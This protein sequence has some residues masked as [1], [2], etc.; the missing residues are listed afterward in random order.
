VL[1]WTYMH[2]IRSSRC[3]RLTHQQSEATYDPS[4]SACLHVYRVAYTQ[5]ICSRR[6]GLAALSLSDTVLGRR[7]SLRV[8]SQTQIALALRGCMVLISVNTVLRLLKRSTCV[9]GRTH[10]V[11]VAI[12]RFEAVVIMED[13][14]ELVCRLSNGAISNDLQ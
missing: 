9:R 12:C 11:V 2:P 4:T 5:A 1:I 7:V 3:S 13:E 14:S 8:R 6:S 10:L